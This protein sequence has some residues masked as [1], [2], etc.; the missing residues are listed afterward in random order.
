MIVLGSCH[1]GSHVISWLWTLVLALNLILDLESYTD[2][3]IVSWLWNRMLDLE[4]YPGAEILSWIWNLMLALESS[5]G[6]G[7]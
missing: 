6:C 7:I 4:S 2:S 5:P 1:P 3:G